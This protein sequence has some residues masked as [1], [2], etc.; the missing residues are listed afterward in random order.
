MGDSDLWVYI[1]S[2]A[3]FEALCSL[4]NYISFIMTPAQK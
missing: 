3:S 1:L 2:Y 4:L